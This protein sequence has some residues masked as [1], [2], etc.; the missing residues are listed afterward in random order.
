[1]GTNPNLFYKTPIIVN[2]NPICGLEVS[3]RP[4]THSD[5]YYAWVTNCCKILSTHV[6]VTFGMFKAGRPV[7]IS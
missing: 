4:G 7:Q 6:M 2:T 3:G 1:M 5:L